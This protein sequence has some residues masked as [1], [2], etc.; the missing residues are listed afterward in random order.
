MDMDTQN[1]A[2]DIH[3]I[4]DAGE[5]TLTGDLME[6]PR[7]ILGPDGIKWIWSTANEFGCPTNGVLP[8]V[9]TGY[10]RFVASERLNKMES[11]RVCLTVGG[12]TINYPGL[13]KQTTRAH[14]TSQTKQ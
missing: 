3:V 6:V 9:P 11:K 12:N 14:Q 7:L 10:S 4:C 8:N 5:C 2:F 1:A 13:S